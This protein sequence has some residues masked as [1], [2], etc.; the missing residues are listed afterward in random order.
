MVLN[1]NLVNFWRTWTAKELESPL[2]EI[3]KA[4]N[5]NLV[6]TTCFK[7]TVSKN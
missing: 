7:K 4:Y 2:L 6:M 1:R 3:Y 5:I